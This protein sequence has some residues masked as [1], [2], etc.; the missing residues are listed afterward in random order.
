M[1]TSSPAARFSMAL[2][3]VTSTIAR[4]GDGMTKTRILTVLSATMLSILLA[5]RTLAQFG[6]ANPPSAAPADLAFT[7]GRI[8]TPSGWADSVAIHGVVIVAVGNTA[9]IKPHVDSRTRTIDLGGKTVLPG[10]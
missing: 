2:A 4:Q 10:L 7:N 3:S 1:T 8:Y 6:P 5:V 9:A